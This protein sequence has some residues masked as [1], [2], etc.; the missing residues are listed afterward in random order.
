MVEIVFS[1]N[2]AARKQGLFFRQFSPR[3]YR[4]P[5]GLQNNKPGI[6][7]HNDFMKNDRCAAM[8]SINNRIIWPLTFLHSALWKVHPTRRFFTTAHLLSILIGYS[9]RPSHDRLWFTDPDAAVF[10]DLSKPKVEGKWFRNI[11]A[12]SCQRIRKRLYAKHFPLDTHKIGGHQYRGARA[13]ELLA[14]G[15]PAFI[16]CI[17]GRWRSLKA[18][19]NYLATNVQALIGFS[20]LFPSNGFDKSQYSGLAWY[21]LNHRLLVPVGNSIRDRIKK[22]EGK[23]PF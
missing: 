8:A 2:P 19:H 20:H 23:F 11:S 9:I 14:L 12:S 4:D 17:L 1:D 16:V 7:I 10:P 22:S 18:M 6:V 5:S 15:V 21:Y 3:I 13:L